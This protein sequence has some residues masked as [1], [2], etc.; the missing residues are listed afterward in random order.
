MEGTQLG[1]VGRVR[2]QSPLQGTFHEEGKNKH[3][4]ATHPSK[5]ILSLSVIGCLG[6]LMLQT[7]SVIF[8]L[9]GL[10]IQQKFT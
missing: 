7:C 6:N 5:A 8:L 10:F 4:Y 9:S 1:V 2:E 3:V